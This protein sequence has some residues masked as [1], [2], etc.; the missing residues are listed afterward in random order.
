MNG[1]CLGFEAVPTIGFAH[2]FR[3][4]NYMQDMTNIKKPELYDNKGIEIVYIKEGSIIAEIYGK[5]YTIEP[6]S[7]VIILRALPFRLYAKDSRVRTHCSLELRTGYTYSII[8]ESADADKNSP[9]FLLPFINPPCRENEEIKKILFS[10]VSNVGARGGRGT[11]CDSSD[12]MHILS[13]L[14]RMYRASLYE[15]AASVTEYRIKAYIAD[16]I[17]RAI[18][19]CEIAEYLGKTPNYLNSVFKKSAGTGIHSYINSEK[20]RIISELI[21]ERKLPFKEACESVGIEDISYGYRMFK[22]HT[23]LTPSQFTE[24]KSYRG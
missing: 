9:N 7:I 10:I 20:V 17:H 5:K 6:G 4:E 16:R 19:L 23:G 22:K 18:P 15:S 12:A 8:H 24:S 1:I 2:H 14:D 3:M 21:L 13:R 11:V